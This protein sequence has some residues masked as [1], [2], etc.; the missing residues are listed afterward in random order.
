MAMMCVYTILLSV[1]H[2]HLT[3]SKTMRKRIMVTPFPHP[4]WC[5]DHTP[6]VVSRENQA[7]AAITDSKIMTTLRIHLLLIISCL[8][9]KCTVRELYMCVITLRTCICNVLC[10]FIIW[11]GCLIYV[12]VCACIKQYQYIQSYTRVNSKT[13]VQNKPQVPI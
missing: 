5:P 2:S 6:K 12:F 10:V 4:K 11:T 8:L 3:N 9:G 1:D 13:V 7:S